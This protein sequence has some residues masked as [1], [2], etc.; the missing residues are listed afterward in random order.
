MTPSDPAQA[1]AADQLPERAPIDD[2]RSIRE[3]LM[4][5]GMREFARH[6]FRGS[7]LRRITDSV[8]VS[9]GNVGHVFGSKREFFEDVLRSLM[10]PV[11]L[12]HEAQLDRLEA[13]GA[14]PD[15]VELFDA[16]AK[17]LVGLLT[18]EEGAL[19]GLFL[20]HSV[21]E[22]EVFW[23]VVKEMQMRVR[24]RFLALARRV[25]DHLPAEEADYRWSQAVRLFFVTLTPSTQNVDQPE[26]V[27][28]EGIEQVRRLC[29]MM[30]RGAPGA[31][32]QL[33][34][35]PWSRS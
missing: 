30:L 27:S 11:C 8:G 16:H 31:E 2:D 32:L 17:G 24:P 7:S 1:A 6:G 22:H 35:A 23:P 14:A 10:L 26:V 3:R 25:L 20:W 34:P 28:P 9:V 18:H 5:A 13:P 21:T 4:E 33:P 12:S 19:R 29:I 15:V